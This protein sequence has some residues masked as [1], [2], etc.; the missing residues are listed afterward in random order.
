MTELKQKLFKFVGGRILKTGLAAFLTAWICDAL[1]LP[2]LFAVITAIVTVEP[3]AS[4]SI[5]K[6]HHTFSSSGH[7]CWICDVI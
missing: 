2:V 5:K 7:R 4:D 3:T 1:G 6:G